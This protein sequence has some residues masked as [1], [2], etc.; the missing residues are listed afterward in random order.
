MV[1]HEATITES[2][3][4]GVP[5]EDSLTGWVVESI[6]HCHQTKAFS[7]FL[8]AGQRLPSLSYLINM[9]TCYIREPGRESISQ[10]EIKLFG[11]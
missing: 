3:V 5:S 9:A 8:T 11:S 6:S 7:F 1:S 4:A 2:A 10:I